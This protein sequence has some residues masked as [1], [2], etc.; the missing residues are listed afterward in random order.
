LNGQNITLFCLPFS[1]GNIYSYRK[2]ETCLADFIKPVPLE[3]PGHGRRL[4]EP[5]L[6]NVHEMVDDI[7]RQIEASLTSPYAIYGHSMGTVTGYLLAHKIVNEQK[8]LPLHLFFSGH[9]T[10]AVRFQEEPIHLLPDDQFVQK[11]LKYGGIPKEVAAEKDLMAL[12]IPIMKADFRALHEYT[13]QEAELLHIPLTAIIGTDEG[14]SDEDV[15][16]WQEVTSQD[17]TIKKY[18]GDHFFIFEHLQEIG[19][20]ISQTLQPFTN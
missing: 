3:L 12:F 15:L 5:L 10:P 9:G 8:P 1:G 19:H 11:V 17:I 20:L 4:R 16:A 13:Y 7:F 2:L 6:S 14:I 18:T